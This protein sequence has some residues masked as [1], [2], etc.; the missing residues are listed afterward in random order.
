MRVQRIDAS[1]PAR[2]CR[3]LLFCRRLS[4]SWQ[5]PD[6]AAVCRGGADRR[7]R[8]A[9]LSHA[10]RPR[11]RRSQRHRRGNESAARR[12]SS[13][14]WSRGP[15]PSSSWRRCRSLQGY[16]IADYGYQLGRHWGIGQKGKNNGA[17]LI[18]APNERKVRIEVGYGL[19]GVL[20]DAVTR[21]IIE[22]AILPRFRAS[23]FS[24]GIERGVDDIMQV[25]S[26]DA[27]DFKRA[28]RERASRPS[29]QEGIGSFILVLLI[30]VHLPHM[31]S[32]SRLVRPQPGYR[33][34][35]GRGPVIRRRSEAAAGGGWGHRAGA[36]R[37]GRRRFLGWRRFVRRRRLIGELVTWR[38]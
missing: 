33:T 25:L 38:A 16:D 13:R 6:G 28:R 29:G 8:A 30:L 32:H 14:R 35:W 7:G 22:N 19:E 26:G 10:D 24:G 17:L 18:V 15:A 34:G 12:A 23:D 20:T 37:L 9:A 2:A 4:G 11:G 31:L 5:P 21:L 1:T 27:E 36:E 3:R